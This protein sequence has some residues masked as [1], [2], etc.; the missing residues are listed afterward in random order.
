MSDNSV[1]MKTICNAQM[2]IKI[3]CYH[4]LFK[5]DLWIN[6]SVLAP[7]VASDASEHIILYES[8]F[9]AKNIMFKCV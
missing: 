2:C 1:L 7:E 4:R 9:D 8:P 6:G 5:A 3:T